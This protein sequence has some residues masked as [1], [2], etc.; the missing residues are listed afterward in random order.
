MFEE[1]PVLIVNEWSDIT[2]ELLDKTIIEFQNKTFN[3]DK[4]T[5]QYWVKKINNNI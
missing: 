3:Y 1:L 2:K 5:L 4:L